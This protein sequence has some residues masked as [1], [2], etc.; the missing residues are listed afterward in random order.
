MAMPWQLRRISCWRTCQLNRGILV[1]NGKQ[2][3]YP[4]TVRYIKSAKRLTLSLHSSSC[5]NCVITT[6]SKAEA[7]KCFAS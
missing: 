6:V 4:N 2:H 7:I 1:R 3:R 5:Q